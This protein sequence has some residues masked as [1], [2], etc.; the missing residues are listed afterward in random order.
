MKDRIQMD[1]E[2]RQADKR[3]GVTVKK[4]VATVAEQVNLDQEVDLGAL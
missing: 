2:Q 3:R 4:P 1:R